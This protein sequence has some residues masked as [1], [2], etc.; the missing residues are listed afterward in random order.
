MLQE[1]RRTIF[2]SHIPG[3]QIIQKFMCEDRE[4][5]STKIQQPGTGNVILIR[6]GLSHNILEWACWRD[7][8]L[9]AIVFERSERVEQQ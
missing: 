6:N 3:Y 7:Q 1:V 4:I 8:I 9:T 2:N 5:F